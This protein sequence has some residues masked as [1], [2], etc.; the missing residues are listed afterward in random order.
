MRTTPSFI[1]VKPIMAFKIVVFPEPLI[2]IKH[3]ISAFF[4]VKETSF[5]TTF[6]PNDLR[7][8]FT[9]IT[10]IPSYRIGMIFLFVRYAGPFLRLFVYFAGPFLRLFVYF[11]GLF[12]QLFC[13]CRVKFLLL[14]VLNLIGGSIAFFQ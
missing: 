2:P 10:V 5:R 8:F 7:I 13:C 1:G 4:A 9:S 3:V 12:F 11:A 6:E 14:L